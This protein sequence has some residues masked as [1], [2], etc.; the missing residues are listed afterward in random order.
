MLS[1]LICTKNE[2]KNIERAIKS[3]QGLA[4]E[5][6]VVDSGS[7]DRTVEIAK[8]LGAKV[9]FREWKG[10]PDQQNYGIGLC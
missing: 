8:E 1:V 4:D 5:V 10:Y 9:F 7:T 6:I 3:V 2:E